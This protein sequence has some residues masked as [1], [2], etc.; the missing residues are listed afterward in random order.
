MK[1]LCELLSRCEGP[2]YS[3]IR[4]N[5]YAY[6]CSLDLFMWAGQLSF[7]VRD[8]SEPSKSLFAFYDILAYLETDEGFEDL[9]KDFHIE[10]SKAT[11][12]YREFV[13][14]STAYGVISSG[15]RSVLRV[16]NIHKR[17]I[18]MSRMK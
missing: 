1:V 14:C 6:G 8:S 11:T 10:T 12:A 16:L 4:G 9:C 2:L 5:G 17:V 3:A 7:E 13:S 15:L 18:K